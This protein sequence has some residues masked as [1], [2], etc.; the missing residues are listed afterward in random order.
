M[1]PD[2]ESSERYGVDQYDSAVT[3]IPFATLLDAARS[4]AP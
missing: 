4:Q 2:A 3:E 1:S